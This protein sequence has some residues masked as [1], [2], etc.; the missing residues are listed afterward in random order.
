MRQHRKVGPVTRLV[1][2]RGETRHGRA[3]EP[4]VLRAL[5]VSL[6]ETVSRAENIDIY[7]VNVGLQVWVPD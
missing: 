1:M 4:G 6:Q 2:R 3:Q 7:V 5:Q